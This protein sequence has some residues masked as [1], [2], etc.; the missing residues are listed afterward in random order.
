MQSHPEPLP[1]DGWPA[2]IPWTA[3]AWGGAP[4]QQPIAPPA[5]VQQGTQ[6]G[7]WGQP[8]PEVAAAIM[9]AYAHHERA[10]SMAPP[11][12]VQPMPGA[13]HGQPPAG[14]PQ[15]QYAPTGLAPVLPQ[16]F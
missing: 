15:P 3:S 10:Q 12:P 8:G 16:G 1:P 5:P 11:A 14:P 6:P 2:H 7:P 9:A 13:I 4:P